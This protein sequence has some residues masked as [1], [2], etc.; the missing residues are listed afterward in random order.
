M[1]PAY[2]EGRTE[3]VSP[4]RGETDSV[5]VEALAAL[6][7]ELARLR[8]PHEPRGRRHA[9]LAQLL[10]QRLARVHMHVE[11]DQVEERARAHRPTGTAGHAGVEVLR[12]DPRLVEHADAVVQQR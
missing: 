3:T 6:A 7:A 1:G 2:G 10:V 5:G 4:L 11:A 9:R 8:H 12:G